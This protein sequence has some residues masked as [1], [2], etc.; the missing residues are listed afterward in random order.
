MENILKKGILPQF[1]T[2]LIYEYNPQHRVDIYFV[3]RE[4]IQKFVH[5][6]TMKYV[7]I[8]LKEKVHPYGCLQCKHCSRW[9]YES[10]T[11]KDLV[12]GKPI[13]CNEDCKF[14]NCCKFIPKFRQWFS[15][16]KYNLQ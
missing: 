8:E 16:D 13:Y 9:F 15:V 3:H 6:K 4:L 7:F 14:K 2:N 11:M 10:D 12:F 1:I 5:L